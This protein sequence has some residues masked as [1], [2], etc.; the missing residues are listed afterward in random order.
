MK[1]KRYYKK[2]RDKI[3]IKKKIYYKKNKQ[4]RKEQYANLTPER[5]AELSEIRKLNMR[6]QVARELIL[7]ANQ[8]RL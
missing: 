6:K 7:K 1:K 3:L 5:K 8:I 4:R 2:H